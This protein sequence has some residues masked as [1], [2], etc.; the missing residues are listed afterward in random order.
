MEVI[1]PDTLRLFDELL[2]QLTLQASH[3]DFERQAARVVAAKREIALALEQHND[4]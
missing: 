4:N 2:S 3:P 1:S